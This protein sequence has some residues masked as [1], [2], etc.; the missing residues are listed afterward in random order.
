[1]VSNIIYDEKN[2]NLYLLLYKLGKGSYSTVWFSIQFKSFVNNIK[3][4]KK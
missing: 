1:M 3:I 4:K 2:D